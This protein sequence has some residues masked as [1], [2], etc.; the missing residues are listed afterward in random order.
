[1]IAAALTGAKAPRLTRQVSASRAA[2]RTNQLFYHAAA[3]ALEGLRIGGE[4]PAGDRLPQLCEQ[5]KVIVQVVYGIEPRAQDFIDALQMMQVRAAEVAAGVAGAGRV[6][7]IRVG[8]MA[9]VADLD[10]PVG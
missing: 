8:A 6:E 9:G 3:V 7:R 2:R 5:R 10:V 4:R 1:M